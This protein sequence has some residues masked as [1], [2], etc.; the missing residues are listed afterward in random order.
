MASILLAVS[1]AGILVTM[2]GLV[3]LGVI[4]SRKLRDGEEERN[5]SRYRRRM[6]LG[7]LESRHPQTH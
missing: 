3:A 7:M 4:G 1:A 5:L 6:L 2:V